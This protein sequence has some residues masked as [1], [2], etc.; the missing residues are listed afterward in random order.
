MRTI[1]SLLTAL[2]FLIGCSGSKDQLAERKTK[3]T[4]TTFALYD[5]A[6]NVAQGAFVVRQL[7]PPGK[8]VHTFEPTPKDLVELQKSAL[9]LYSGAGL[10]PWAKRFAGITNSVDMSRYVKLRTFQNHHHNHH[11]NNAHHKHT[12]AIDPHYWLDVSNMERIVDVLARKFAALEP[13]KQAFFLQ[14]A[15]NYK[16]KLAKL[17]E[18]AKEMFRKC[19]KKEIFVNHNA[20]SYMASRYGFKVDSLTGLSP[21]AQPTP[22][23]IEAVLKKIK[24]ED[25]KVIFYEPF[26]NNAVLLSVAR[27]AGVR[28]EVL[29]S[30]A[31]VTAQDAK[32]H[33]GYI[34][35][36]RENIQKV[37]Q[38]L[39]CD[40]F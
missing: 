8:E 12:G 40:A 11:D 10:E 7:I 14:K 22:Q 21:D 35:L 33:K 30:L 28:T 26:E 27:D 39:E 36:M 31:N 24:E 4:A 16:Q 18:K 37:A 34:D 9:F 23:T 25:I 38:A 15:K 13:T 1:I 3:I 20:Y 17:D 29:Q 2:F 6:K 19:R 5:A 32:M